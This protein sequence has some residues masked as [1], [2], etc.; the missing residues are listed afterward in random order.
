MQRQSHLVQHSASDCG[1]KPLNTCIVCKK[2]FDSL[3]KLREHRNTHTADD[4]VC[5]ICGK[6]CGNYLRLRAHIDVHKPIEERAE[7]PFCQ[8]KFQRETI[9]RNHIAKHTGV[10]PYQCRIC[11]ER[12][13][14]FTKLQQHMKARPK[15]CKLAR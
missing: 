12:F 2:S 9:M 13:L 5:D 6:Q 11:D 1:R 8:K 3:K 7:C 10:K 14:T 4:M 15:T